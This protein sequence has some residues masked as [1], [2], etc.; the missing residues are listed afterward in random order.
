M[1]TEDK[2]LQNAGYSL[3]KRQEG[4][5][6]MMISEEAVPV[7]VECGNANDLSIK[8]SQKFRP[9]RKR[10]RQAGKGSYSLVSTY[11]NKP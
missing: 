3:L 1:G 9:K 7:S 6:D 10:H 5:H 4:F 8:G 11:G 2:S